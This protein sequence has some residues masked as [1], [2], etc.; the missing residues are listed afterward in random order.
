VRV[1][2]EVDLH[3][4]DKVWLSPDPAHLHRFDAEGLRM[5]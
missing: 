4:G 1:G 5:A 3:Y 2:G